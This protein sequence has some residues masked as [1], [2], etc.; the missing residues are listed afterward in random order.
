[1][2]YR[3]RRDTPG[4]CPFAP[5][6]SQASA[7]PASRGRMSAIRALAPQAPA[8][9]I[10]RAP[11]R[12]DGP[13]RGRSPKR[14]NRTAGGT[15]SRYAPVL[16]DGSGGGQSRCPGRAIGAVRAARGVVRWAGRCPGLRDPP[17][18]RPGHRIGHARGDGG[19]DGLRGEETAARKAAVEAI[20]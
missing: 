13:P 5:A 7:V 15:R 19:Y 4:S 11:G 3:R 14:R 9:V 17:T 12:P 18:M 10:A 20:G 16:T 2:R 6:S 1:M 8:R